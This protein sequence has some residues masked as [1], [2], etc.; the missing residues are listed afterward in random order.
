[1]LAV[2]ITLR[3]IPS[4]CLH[5]FST[6]ALL[7]GPYPCAPVI[8]SARRSLRDMSTKLGLQP[9]GVR[10]PLTTDLQGG[11]VSQ[12]VARPWLRRCSR[13]SGCR[14]DIR[15]SGGSATPGVHA[16]A[17]LERS[18]STW[19]ASACMRV[20]AIA[21]T[22]EIVVFNRRPVAELADMNEL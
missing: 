7:Y 11:F 21:H 19:C 22:T 15:P 4:A 17:Q 20:L 12:G 5:G 14:F 1:M 18:T 2:S 3:W 9:G 13:S 16:G 8:C 6:P 10:Y